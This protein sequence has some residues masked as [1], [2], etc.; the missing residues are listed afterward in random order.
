MWSPTRK[1]NVM[2][3]DIKVSIIIP[4]YNTYSY[5]EK[6]VYSLI[7]QTYSNFEVLLID[8]GSTDKSYQLC[9]EFAKKD[10]RIQVWKKEN[11]GLSDTR[12]FGLTKVSGEYVM[13][14]DSDDWFEL[15]MLERFVE[16]ISDFT[17]D[18]V[19]QGFQVDFEEEGASYYELYETEL[20]VQ[21]GEL[22][23]AILVT[24][25]AGLLNS[26]CNKLYKKKN[27]DDY[28]MQFVRNQ[29]PAEDLLFNCQYFSKIHSIACLKYAGYHYVKRGVH[30]LTVKYM[31]AYEKRI[32]EFYFARKM[33]YENIA[34]PH[35]ETDILLKNS[36]ASYALTAF[37]NMYRNTSP[38]NFKERSVAIKYLYEVPE[39]VQ[40]ILSCQYSNFFLKILQVMT[41]TKNIFLTNVIFSVLYGCR[42]RFQKVY[43]KFRKRV[44]YSKE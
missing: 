10:S 21:E 16:K 42:Y 23:S 6:C 34:M 33:L 4:V 1:A 28:N 11:G 22:Y 9:E 40:A 19:I 20:C 30:S 31:T 8:D 13:F 27:I 26:S 3:K 15:D 29:E 14:L 32:M 24:E 25:K 38:L 41:K 7:G 39:I 37:S 35:V 2:K 5:L 43:V 18:V 12:N 36:L 17:Y 44:L